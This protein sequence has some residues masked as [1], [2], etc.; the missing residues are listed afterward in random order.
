MELNASAA[1]GGMLGAA[2]TNWAS[3]DSPT[4][5]NDMHRTANILIVILILYLCR[6]L[7]V[8]KAD[9]NTDA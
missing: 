9:L 1:P 3:S 2:K 6:Q 8:T 7:I 4:K 5:G